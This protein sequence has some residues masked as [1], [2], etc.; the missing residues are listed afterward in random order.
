MKSILKK[1]S[2]FILLTLTLTTCKKSYIINDRQ[3][4]LFQ[5]EYINS[6]WGYQHYGFFIDN[7]GNVLTYR[8]PDSWNFRDKNLS[9]TGAQVSENLSKCTKSKIKISQDELQKYSGYIK[10]ISASKVTALKN[11]G[12]DAGSSEYLCY[13][14]SDDTDIYTSHLIKME[15]DF[16]RE[17]LNFYSKK[18]VA[19]M[20]EI[21]N[22][23]AGNN[24]LIP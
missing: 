1:I 8:N 9:L 15:G 23:L 21:N 5:F 11:V 13:Q 24:N 12:A 3:F 10:N 17:N 6:A 19:W 20:K 2:F 22:S 18:V 16:T 14:F 4:I 7:E